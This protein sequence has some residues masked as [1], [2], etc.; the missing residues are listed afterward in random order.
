MSTTGQGVQWVP[1]MS[2]FVVNWS[3]DLKLYQISVVQREIKSKSSH[4][5]TSPA[6]KSQLRCRIS[7]KFNFYFT[8]YDK[9]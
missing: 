7:G 4:V 8:I 6:L 9:K 5:V 2:E 3:T 1:G